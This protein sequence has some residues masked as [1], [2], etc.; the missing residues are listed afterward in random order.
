MDDSIDDMDDSND[1]SIDDMDDSNDD[2]NG[3]IGHTMTAFE[4]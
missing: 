2:I 4:T 3:S 1:D